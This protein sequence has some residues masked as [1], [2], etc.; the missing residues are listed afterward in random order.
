[1]RAT[2]FAATRDE[3]FLL[4]VS[5]DE[6][7]HPFICP[8][9]FVSAFDDFLLPMPNADDPL[10]DKPRAQQEWAAHVAR[11][12][13]PRVEKDGRTYVRNPPY[14]ACNSFCDHE[15]G[16]VLSAME[17]TVPDALVVYHVGPRGD[18]R[19]AQALGQRAGDVRG[20]HARAADLS[21]AGPGA[22]GRDGGA[23]S[24]AH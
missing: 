11:W 5:I 21:L 20:D 16:R 14:F 17:E 12:G 7:H 1:M 13:G 3:D 19:R 6:P 10:I 22:G 18:V 2:L 9:P 23:A 8:E 24:V 15:V 4:V